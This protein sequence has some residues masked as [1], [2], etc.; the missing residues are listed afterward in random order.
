MREFM[1]KI[2]ITN[3]QEIANASP[4]PRATSDIEKEQ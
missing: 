2:A 1:Q 4:T 3:I